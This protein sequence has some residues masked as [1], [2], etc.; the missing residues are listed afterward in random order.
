MG[1]QWKFL[2]LDFFL[3]QKPASN[4]LPKS[5]SLLCMMILES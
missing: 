5:L 2:H 3:K 1:K 4:Y